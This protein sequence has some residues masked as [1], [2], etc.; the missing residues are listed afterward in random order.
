MEEYLKTYSEINDE[1]RRAALYSDLNIQKDEDFNW[2]K[3]C[4]NVWEKIIVG[5]A[6]LGYLTDSTPASNS[7]ENKLVL[8]HPLALKKS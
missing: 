7:T 5:S 6:E 8:T 4:M 1:D 2:Y 3:E